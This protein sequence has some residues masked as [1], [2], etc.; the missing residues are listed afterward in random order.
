MKNN[1]KIHL[2]HLT[3]LIIGLNSLID[4]GLHEGISIA[5]A[6]DAIRSGTVFTWLREKFQKNIDLSLYEANA[7]AREAISEEWQALLGGYEGSE[8]RKWGVRNN[9][10][11]LLLAWTNELVQQ[12]EWTDR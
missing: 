9:G 6:E 8:G 5:E 3:F 7:D 11:C 4:G 1:P 12:R 2:T 10:I